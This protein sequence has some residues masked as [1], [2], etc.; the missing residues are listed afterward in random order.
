MTACFRLLKCLTSASVDTSPASEKHGPSL[1]A[2]GKKKQIRWSLVC[3]NR[4]YRCYKLDGTSMGAPVEAPADSSPD[5]ERPTTN[6]FPELHGTPHSV[7]SGRS[8][9]SPEES[10]T[11]NTKPHD[12]IFMKRRALCTSLWRIWNATIFFLKRRTKGI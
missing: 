4:A 11:T 1:A 12:A 5:V 8:T 3:E 7:S 2:P 6:F 10:I 9:S